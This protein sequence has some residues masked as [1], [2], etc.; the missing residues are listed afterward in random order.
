MADFKIQLDIRW[1]DVDSFGHVNNAT[2]L[3][4]LE[5]CR[6]RWLESVPCHWEKG[7]TGPVVA[8]IN[9]NFRRRMHWPLSIEVT[10]QP[11][12]PGRSSIKLE[13]EI[14]SLVEDNEDPVVYA[15]ATVTLVWIDKKSGESV[16]LPKVIRELGQGKG[17]SD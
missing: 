3:T 9:V 2:Y 10:L 16:P 11:Q 14:R 6:S 5:E 8:S 4:Y 12:S 13:S 15:D 17:T 7:D 1:A